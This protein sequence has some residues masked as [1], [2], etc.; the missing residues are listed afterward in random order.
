MAID[1]RKNQVSAA[2]LAQV[3]VFWAFCA[4]VVSLDMAKPNQRPG[5]SHEEVIKTKPNRRRGEPHDEVIKTKPN[6][7]QGKSHHEVMKAKLS[8]DRKV[9]KFRAKVAAS[10]IKEPDMAMMQK[11]FSLLD[12]RALWG[13]LATQRNKESSPEPTQQQISHRSPTSSNRPQLQA[14]VHIFLRGRKQ[15]RYLATVYTL[16]RSSLGGTRQHPYI[17]LET[18]VT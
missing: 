6:Q 8:L 11:H 7:R 4:L 5:K 14:T 15:A 17:T 16:P 13:R 10:N 9:A 18:H 1:V 3:L 2:I 12:L